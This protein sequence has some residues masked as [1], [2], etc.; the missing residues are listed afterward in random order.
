ME[1]KKY[2]VPS[3]NTIVVEASNM[4]A[5]SVKSVSGDGPAKGSDITSGE[6]GTK[7]SGSWNVWSSD[8]E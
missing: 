2:I 7:S 5:N 1:K 6:A 3:T 4:I 8:D